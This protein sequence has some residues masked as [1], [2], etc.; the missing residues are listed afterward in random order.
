MKTPF[1]LLA[2]LLMSA[3]A[4]AQNTADEE[5]AIKAVC[6]DF[7]EQWDK[8]N[9]SAVLAHLADV[10]Y[11]SR[12][13]TNNAYNGSATIR[14]LVAKAFDASPT[15]TGVKR[16]T[17]NW[18]LKALGSNHYWVTY[19]QAITNRDG[20]LK[21]EKEARLLEKIAQSD[22]SGQ[23]KLVSFITLPMAKPE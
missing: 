20:K 2:L 14:E 15:P 8:R 17:S 5:A 18:Q 9:R 11:A 7:S 16:E 12:Y 23:W 6:T 1:L 4:M 22:G 10:P 3:G 21:Y 13:W 19:S